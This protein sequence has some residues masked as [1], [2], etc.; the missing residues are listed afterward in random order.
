MALTDNTRDYEILV[1]FRPDGTVAAHRQ[2]IREISDGDEVLSAIP[3]SPT[4]LTI[5]A[6]KELVAALP[7]D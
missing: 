2:T 1:R 7:D 5:A 6:L 3:Q 4:P